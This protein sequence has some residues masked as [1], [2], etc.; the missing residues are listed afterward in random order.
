MDNDQYIKDTLG[1]D[2]TLKTTLNLWVKELGVT[3]LGKHL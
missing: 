2:R 1:Q 3:L